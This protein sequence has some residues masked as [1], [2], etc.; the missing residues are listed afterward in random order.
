MSQKVLVVEDDD[1][2]RDALALLLASQGY[3]LE[4]A[5]DG[6]AA[7]SKAQ[8]FHPDVLI[9]DWLLPGADGIAVARTIQEGIEP[10]PVI[11]VTAHSVPDLRHRARD[12]RVHAYLPKPIDV[13]RLRNVLLALA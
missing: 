5:G 2:A 13:G 7:I 11:F 12:L 9:C 1:D 8:A 3:E 6:D 10:I 4:T